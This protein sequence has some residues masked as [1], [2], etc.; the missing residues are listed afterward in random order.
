MV[1]TPPEERDGMLH[2]FSIK[3]ETNPQ[4]SPQLFGMNKVGAMRLQHFEM[5]DVRV[6]QKREAAIEPFVVFRLSVVSAKESPLLFEPRY[7]L[8]G[9]RCLPVPPAA[10]LRDFRLIEEVAQ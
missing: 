8:S 1:S 7:R 5:G 4:M 2:S 6:G 10:A 9:K 3:P